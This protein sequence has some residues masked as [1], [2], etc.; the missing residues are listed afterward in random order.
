[1]QIPDLSLSRQIYEEAK[2]WG[3]AIAAAWVI[4]RGIDWIKDIKDNHLT[5]IQQGINDFNT[6]LDVSLKAQTDQIVKATQA[7][8]G[9]ITELRGDIKMLTSAM[10]TQTARAASARKKKTKFDK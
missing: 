7:N 8:T 1:M 2:F 5:H 9:E 6:K 10:I 3:P 4:F